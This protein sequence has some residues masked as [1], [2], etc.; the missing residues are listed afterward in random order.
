MTN[1]SG[2]WQ[3]ALLYN[4]KLQF[5][6]YLWALTG[7]QA[8]GKNWAAYEIWI[9]CHFRCHIHD[10]AP[11]KRYF[12]QQPN[13]PFSFK[14]EVGRAHFPFESPQEKVFDIIGNLIEEKA[15]SD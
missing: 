15:M 3:Q 14:Q 11:A 7:C 6:T 1:T 4:C 9:Q 5:I 2:N 10:T 13:I 12:I 8:E